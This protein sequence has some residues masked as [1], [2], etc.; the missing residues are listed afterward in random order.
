MKKG[1]HCEVAKE[2]V[3]NHFE[4]E[5][6]DFDEII[7]RLTLHYEEMIDIAINTSYLSVSPKNPFSH[8]LIN[9]NDIINVILFL[10]PKAHTQVELGSNQAKLLM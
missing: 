1:T 8:K 3:K 9:K 4:N 7:L 2:A 6:K 10:L 5:A